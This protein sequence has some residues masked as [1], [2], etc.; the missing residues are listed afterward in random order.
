MTAQKKIAQTPPL[1]KKRARGL[2]KCELFITGDI[3]S[4]LDVQWEVSSDSIR[5]PRGRLIHR[6]QETKPDKSKKA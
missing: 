1:R 4:P 2:L 3:I 6:R 5:D